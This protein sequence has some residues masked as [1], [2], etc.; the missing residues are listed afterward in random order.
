[1]ARYNKPVNAAFIDR[2]SAMN[3][4]VKKMARKG[5]KSSKHYPVQRK[6]TMA[7]ELPSVATAFEVRTDK[8]LSNVNHRLYRQSRNYVVKVD[9]DSDLPEGGVV[10]VYALQDTWMNMKAYQ[11]AKETFDENSNEE[12]EML[13]K[14]RARWNDFRVASGITGQTPFDA[15]GFD[16][17][18]TRYTGGEYLYSEVHDTGGTASTFRWVGTGANTFNIIDEYDRTGDTDQTPTFGQTA[19]AY[20]GLE[21]E[22]DD[23]QMD[24]LSNEGNNPPYTARTIENQVFTKV[25][26]LY[27]DAGGGNK[28][29]TGFFNAPCGLVYITTAGGINGTTIGNKIHVEVKGGDYKGVHAPSYLE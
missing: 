6:I 5:K 20:D 18:A 11:L 2:L 21:D 22:L 19:V 12:L 29:S 1:M 26:T 13:G 14:N 17:S 27:V 8:L 7:V 16:P 23:G 10:E 4:K 24:H 28:L 25:A 9:I 3:P 15:V